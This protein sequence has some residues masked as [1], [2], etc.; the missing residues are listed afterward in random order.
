[1]SSEEKVGLP[2]EASRSLKDRAP[3]PKGGERTGAPAS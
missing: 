1:M 2:L 3:T